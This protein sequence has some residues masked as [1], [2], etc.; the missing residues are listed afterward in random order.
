MTIDISSIVSQI[1]STLCAGIFLAAIIGI[2]VRI[3]QII[4]RR[5]N[6]PIKV[7]FG[8]SVVYGAYI[9]SYAVI[10]SNA[11]KIEKD[12]NVFLRSLLLRDSSYILP[13]PF[14]INF[15]NT[16]DLK[17]PRNYHLR[18]VEIV[19]KGFKIEEKYLLSKSL[20]H[21]EQGCQA[22]GRGSEGTFRIYFPFRDKLQLSLFALSSIHNHDIQKGINL[23]A[24]SYSEVCFW[25]FPFNSGRYVFDVFIDLEELGKRDRIRVAHDIAI[26][27][28]DNFNWLRE[29]YYVNYDWNYPTKEDQPIS[30]EYKKGLM[31]SINGFIELFHNSNYEIINKNKIQVNGIINE[32][33][34][35]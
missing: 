19:I 15:T 11:K 10:P 26:I 23:P 29:L 31:E 25:I 21:A 17:N 35:E 6:F 16:S 33:Y 28:V 8:P 22:G 13:I 34:R 14:V 20:I 27:K 18:E 5:L 24:D 2:G 7:Q 9:G 1:I 12:K 30:E 3:I 32:G 4:A